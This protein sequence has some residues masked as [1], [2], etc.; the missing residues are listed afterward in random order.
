[1]CLL[2]QDQIDQGG[3]YIYTTLDPAV[4]NVATQALESH[5]NENRAPIEFSSS[6]KANYHPPEEGE[7]SFDAIFRRS[8]GGD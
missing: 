5:P 3:L 4:Q 1:M 6:S 8:G 7:D 2:T